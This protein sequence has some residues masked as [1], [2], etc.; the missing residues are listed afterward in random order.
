MTK[1]TMDYWR[2]MTTGIATDNLNR[3]ERWARNEDKKNKG[4]TQK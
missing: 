3:V 2:D 1:R 4:K